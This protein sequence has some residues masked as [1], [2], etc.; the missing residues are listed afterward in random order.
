[1]KKI[2]IIILRS[3]L[4]DIL[5]TL[6]RLR[7]VQICAYSELQGDSALT[8]IAGL[9]NI[10]LQEYNASQDSIAAF[11]TERT[12]LFK[13]WIPAASEPEVVLKLS[14][15]ICAWDIQSPSPEESEAVPVKLKWQKLFGIFYKGASMFFSPLTAD[16][17]NIETKVE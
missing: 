12:L 3:D 15:H 16:T 17:K 9:E 6:L 1:M 13:G 7:C 4:E 2:S 14:E 8:S 5:R 11:G 10:D